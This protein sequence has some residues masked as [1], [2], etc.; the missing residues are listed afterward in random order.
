MKRYEEIQIEIDGYF[1]EYIK[2]L[3]DFEKS[4][5]KYFYWSFDFWEKEAGLSFQHY[6]LNEIQKDDTSAHSSDYF[7]YENI[8]ISI[9]NNSLR[10]EIKFR[11]YSKLFKDNNSKGGEA[12]QQYIQEYVLFKSLEL[13]KTDLEIIYKSIEHDKNTNRNQNEVKEELNY[14]S[15]VIQKQKGNFILTYIFYLFSYNKM[16]NFLAKH[17]IKYDLT[18]KGQN[19]IKKLDELDRDYVFDHKE[20]REI[21]REELNQNSKLR[22]KLEVLY[23]NKVEKDKLHFVFSYKGSEGKEELRELL[24]IMGGENEAEYL[25]RGQ[26]NSNWTLDASITREPKYLENES[27]LYYDILSL[28]P[29]AFKEDHSVYERLITMQHYGMPT[30]LLDISRNPLVAIF[31]ACNNMEC[32]NQDGTIFIFSP[33]R[34]RFLNFEDK[35][36]KCLVKIVENE[37]KTDIC[38][39]CHTK[40]ECPNNIGLKENGDLPDFFLENWFAK[41]VAKNQRINN[42]S[43]DF[44][45]VGLNGSPQTLS[46]MIHMTIII[47]PETKEVL[48][49]QLEALNIHGGAVYPDITHMSNYIRSKYLKVRKPKLNFKDPKYFKVAPTRRKTKVVSK[50]KYT[51]ANDITIKQFDFSKIKNK[52]RATQLITFSEFYN[53]EKSGLSKIIDDFLFTEKKPF[54]NEVADI[55]LDKPSK[56]KEKTKIDLTLE[57]IITLAK[58]IGANQKS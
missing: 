22:K 43:G 6:Y 33:I 3:L 21:K 52:D 57:K 44:I 29:D 20:G 42:Q 51:I 12:K 56:L 28:K 26:A 34:D 38:N 15:E 41:G 2:K 18:K 10:N 30:R 4:P 46:E 27:Q 14:I 55:M 39:N 53:L 35:R 1:E 47:D 25:Y 37:D 5:R 19:L 8:E 13:Y 31:F 17:Y 45:F 50:P 24:D 23:V 9:N 58:L 49:Q 11:N 32:K 48:I 16:P 36:L 40:N 54:R 7:D